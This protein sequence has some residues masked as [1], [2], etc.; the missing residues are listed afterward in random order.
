MKKKL[1]AIA[2]GTIVGTIVTTLIVHFLVPEIYW[3]IIAVG[4]FIDMLLVSCF[5]MCSF[6]W[7]NKKVNF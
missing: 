7:I 6:E 2:L 4:A 5:V 1:I 3:L